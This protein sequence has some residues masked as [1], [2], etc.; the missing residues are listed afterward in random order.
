MFSSRFLSG[1]FGIKAVIPKERWGCGAAVLTS[2][3]NHNAIHVNQFQVTEGT[4]TDRVM[5]TGW[6]GILKYAGL[7][8]MR[9][10]ITSETPY[11]AV[12]AGIRARRYAL[13]DWG[14]SPGH[15]VL[16]V[17]H[18]PKMGALAFMDPV[19]AGNPFFGMTL[20]N[21]KAMW[22]GQKHRLPPAYD[23]DRQGQP[24][25]QDRKRVGEPY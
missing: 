15:W 2:I 10:T 21:F 22:E 23:T 5:G 24:G 20:D 11:L 1:L 14:D 13:L 19:R 3:L 9:A 7:K 6:K 17:G 16:A 8:R 12:L 4:G 18:E 25:A